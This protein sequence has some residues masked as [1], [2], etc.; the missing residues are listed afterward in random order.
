MGPW[1]KGKKHPWPFS[2]FLILHL[3]LFRIS[4]SFDKL[5]MSFDGLTML[6]NAEAVSTVEPS[7]LRT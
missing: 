7:T 3:K 2:I 1:V 6:S 5:M 4:H